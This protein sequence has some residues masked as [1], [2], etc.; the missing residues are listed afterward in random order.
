MLRFYLDEDSMDQDLVRALRA[1]GVDVVTPLDDGTVASSDEDVLRHATA[2]GRVLYTF[3]VGDFYD[4][5]TRYLCE[6][7]EHAGLVIAP[8]QRYAIGEQLRRLLRLSAARTP[9]GMKNAVEF[10]SAWA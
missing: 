3:N 4:L 7:R 10:L 2:Q 1:R 5:H 6:G 9:D 8:Q